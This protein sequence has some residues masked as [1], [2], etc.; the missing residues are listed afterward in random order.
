MF[1]IVIFII[2]IVILV[3]GIFLVE[4]DAEVIGTVL[5][6]FGGIIT[7]ISFIVAMC[8]IADGLTDYPHLIGQKQKIET[9]SK[10]KDEIKNAYYQG[11]SGTLIGGDVANVQQSSKV[12]E[13]LNDLA[14][15]TSS[16]N[17]TLAMCKLYKSDSFYRFW[18]KGLFIDKK[19]LELQEIK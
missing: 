14:L 9:L 18:W 6:T 19:V 3:L 8:L 16:Y 5:A 13:Y 12:T 10:F 15:E 17:S 4:R 7:L 2:S 1:W 11:N